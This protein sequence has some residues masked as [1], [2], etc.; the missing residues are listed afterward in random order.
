MFKEHYKLD[1][2]DLQYL[3]SF[4][5]IPWTIKIVYGLLSDNLPICGSHRRSYLIIGS[6]MQLAA[7]MSLAL[8]CQPGYDNG[9]YFATACLCMGSFST[10]MCD[11]IGDSL[12]V[13]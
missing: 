11:V 13:I 8:N 4:V 3:Y 6:F 1:P 2:S 10:A 7:M 9:P 5:M 12:M